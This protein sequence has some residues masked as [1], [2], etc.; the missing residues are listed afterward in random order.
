MT[1]APADPCACKAIKPTIYYP[2]ET[3]PHP[4]PCGIV[5]NLELVETVIVPPREAA[6]WEVP[7]GHFSRIVCAEG[8][9]VGD[10]NLFNR[11]D[12]DEKFYSGETRTLT[13]THVGLGD[14]LFS[15]FPYLCLITTITQDTLDWNGFDEFRRFGARGHRHPLRPYTN[16][17]LSHGGQY[18]H[19]CHSNL[20]RKRCAKAPPNIVL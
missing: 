19:C 8:P 7:A 5:G 6:T 9:Q 4:Q 15:S 1:E 18:H 20:I 11:N 14:Q 16:N 2:T 3:L 13:G 12:L 17:L 10:L